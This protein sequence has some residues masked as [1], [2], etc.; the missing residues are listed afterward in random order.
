MISESNN[1]QECR[2]L[3]ACWH[4]SRIGAYT[5]D[6]ISREVR[7]HEAHTML[8]GSR[9]RLTGARPNLRQVEFQDQG[10]ENENYEW[11]ESEERSGRGASD[12]EVGWL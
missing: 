9:S 12:E 4:D 6:G 1:C 7:L 3:H 8:T 2:R 5:A 10:Q 11:V